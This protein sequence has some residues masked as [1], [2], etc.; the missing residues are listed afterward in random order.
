MHLPTEIRD[1]NRDAKLCI[2][3]MHFGCILR[4]H[5]SHHPQERP[6]PQLGKKPEEEATTTGTSL[7]K[8][9]IRLLLK[10]TGLAGPE[11]EKPRFHDLD[12]LAGTWTR[13]EAAEFDHV[14]AHQR[15]IDPELWE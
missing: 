13:E 14:L 2:M 9:V 8:I 4:N 15:R 12:H 10:A 5:E 6:P 11:R 3:V 1:A 7:N